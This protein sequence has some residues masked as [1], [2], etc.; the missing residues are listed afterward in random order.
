[1]NSNN[2]QGNNKYRIPLPTLIAHNAT[3]QAQRL[4]TT[5]FG[6]P[7][8]K[9]AEELKLR[10]AQIIKTFPDGLKSVAQ[11]HPDRDLI[12]EHNATR[13]EGGGANGY[14]NSTGLPPD[15]IYVPS[16]AGTLPTL[17]EV[18]DWGDVQTKKINGG[19]NADGSVPSKT[20]SGIGAGAFILGAI[21]LGALFIALGERPI[22]NHLNG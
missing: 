10:L 1:M 2:T 4:I 3:E 21:A 8:A 15:I 17:M 9:N 16:Y 7:R 18:G 11:I 5:K 6:Y 14:H 12:L 19:Y 22:K 13:M 20:G